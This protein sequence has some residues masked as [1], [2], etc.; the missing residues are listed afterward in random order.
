MTKTNTVTMIKLWKV[1][2][3]TNERTLITIACTAFGKR[4]LDGVADQWEFHLEENEKLEKEF[5]YR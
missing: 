2:T 3:D 1:N 5:I 4:L